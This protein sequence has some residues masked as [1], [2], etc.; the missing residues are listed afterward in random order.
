MIFYLDVFEASDR[1]PEAR[2]RVLAWSRINFD[3][4]GLS[5]R[6]KFWRRGSDPPF[7]IRFY[8]SDGA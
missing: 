2:G 4:K 6:P 8:S 5:D 7:R 3:Q 1:C